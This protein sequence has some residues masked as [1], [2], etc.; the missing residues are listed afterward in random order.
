M[1]HQQATPDRDP[2]SFP[3]AAAEAAFAAKCTEQ[4]AKLAASSVAGIDM[5]RRPGSF[6]LKKPEKRGNVSM[7]EGCFLGTL[8]RMAI[9]TGAPSV[10]SPTPHT[11][12]SLSLSLCRSVQ[13]NLRYFH[14]AKN[15]V[16]VGVVVVVGVVVPVVVGVVVADVIC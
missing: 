5:I 16:E 7:G 13:F 8:M 4:K 15:S 6:L 3:D 12:V 11:H 10:L 1:R 2:S 14:C 9:G